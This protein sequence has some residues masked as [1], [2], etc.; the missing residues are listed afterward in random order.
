MLEQGFPEIHANF[1]R[2][3]TKN[4]FKI[5][6]FESNIP[7]NENYKF[8]IFQINQYGERKKNKRCYPFNYITFR[9][10]STRYLPIRIL[11]KNIF[12]K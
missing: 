3:R 9:V 4:T 12:E 1:H 5:L 10:K 8:T 6:R 2:N 11:Q 7:E